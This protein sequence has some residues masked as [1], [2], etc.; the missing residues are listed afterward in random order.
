[1]EYYKI[2]SNDAVIGVGTRFL[3]YY[4]RSKTF[5]YCDIAQAEYV[6]DIITETIY[7]PYWMHS[8]PANSPTVEEVDAQ[9]ITSTEYDELYALFYSGEE[10]PSQEDIPSEP[11][12]EPEPA[13]N[14]EHS[15]TIQEMR[16]KIAE[17]TLLLEGEQKPFVAEKTLTA[18]EIV[19]RGSK[20]YIIT[21]VV[22]KGET[23]TPGVNCTETTL[24]K[25]L[26][27]LQEKT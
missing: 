11:E 15:M 5:S 3:R 27:S 16:D 8:P 17:L 24:A 7:H 18:G 9:D 25:V 4:N 20:V 26:N 23:V 22:A 21:S 12:P 14:P 2:I 19:T 6:Q 1:M 13:T 10:L